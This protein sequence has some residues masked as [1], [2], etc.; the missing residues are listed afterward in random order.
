MINGKNSHGAMW[1]IIISIS[2]FCLVS[3]SSSG[4][5]LK[6]RLDFVGG[7]GYPEYMHIGMR[8]QYSKVAQ[9]GFYYGGDLGLD[10][11]IIRTWN[12][13]HMY[14]FGKHSYFSN[15]PVWY[16][17]QGFT[18]SIHTTADR[19]YK[20]SYINLSAGR[21]FNFNSLIAINADMGWILQIREKREFKDPSLDPWYRNEWIWKALIR[22]QLCISL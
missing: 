9:F 2:L 4:Q 17:R 22:V 3:L 10:N 14:S 18:Y 8:Y 19:I 6:T 11:A 15:R 5:L 21:D 20:Y 12:F 16:A 7:I 1:K 13:D